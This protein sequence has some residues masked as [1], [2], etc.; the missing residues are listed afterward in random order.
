[1]WG[2]YLHVCVLFVC[3]CVCVYVCMYVSVYV[4]CACRPKPVLSGTIYCSKGLQCK[5]DSYF[6]PA[7]PAFS[8]IEYSYLDELF[9][10]RSHKQNVA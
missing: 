7:E 4:H 6:Y 9:S 5:V 8:Y 1:V 3:L 2:V 10:N